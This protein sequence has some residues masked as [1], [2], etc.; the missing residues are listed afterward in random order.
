MSSF[1]VAKKEECRVFS[2]GTP[3]SCIV[4]ISSASLARR[5]QERRVPSVFAPP[6]SI[7]PLSPLAMRHER[8]HTQCT[9]EEYGKPS[10]GTCCCLSLPS[11]LVLLSSLVV[12]HERHGC[13]SEEGGIRAKGATTP[14]LAHDVVSRSPL[15]SRCCLSRMP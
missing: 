6:S 3:H 5:E 13:T 7:V 4:A 11:S 8:Q 14:F 1:W 10:P 15:Q 2:L 12:H 9:S